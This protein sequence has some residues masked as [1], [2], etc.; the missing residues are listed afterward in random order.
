ML[1]IFLLLFA[2]YVYNS[3]L[4]LTVSFDLHILHVVYIVQKRKLCGGS[5]SHS[6]YLSVSY[7][8]LVYREVYF[9]VLVF[10]THT[11]LSLLSQTVLQITTKLHAA[12]SLRSR[13]N[14]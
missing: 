2:L 12:Q 4:A 11:L 3:M 6:T 9:K 10:A 14:T 13:H 5:V 7:R 1:L 8:M